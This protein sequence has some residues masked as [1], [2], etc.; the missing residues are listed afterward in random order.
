MRASAASDPRPVDRKMVAAYATV[1][2]RLRA[3]S[4]ATL[5]PCA[6]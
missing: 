6:R 1:G 5:A 4:L 3:S 2:D